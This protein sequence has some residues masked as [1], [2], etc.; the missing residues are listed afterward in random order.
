MSEAK[1]TSDGRKVVVVGNL[2]AEQTIVQ[3]VFVSGDQEI[4][5]GEN[6]VVSSLH[7]QPVESWKEKRLR[8]LEANYEK[9]RKAW[10]REMESMNRRISEA[11]EKSKAQADALFAFAKNSNDTQIQRLHAFLAGDITHFF[12]VNTLRPAIVTWGDDT[13]YQKEDKWGGRNR[14]EAMKLITLMGKANGCLDFRLS[15]YSDGSGGLGEEII[16]CRSY[17]E[18]LAEAQATLDAMAEEYVADDRRSLDLDEWRK[19]DGIV[20]PEAAAKKQAEQ[21]EAG[22]QKKI[23]ELREKLRELGAAKEGAE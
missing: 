18:A 6:F 11:K 23:A 2:N 12:V 8:E 5:S 17:D 20:I 19:I 1:Y 4:P 14:V 9:Q 13:L 22:R 10:E 21:K 3:E 7:D 15:R 16:P